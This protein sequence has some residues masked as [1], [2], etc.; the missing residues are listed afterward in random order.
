MRGGNA[1]RSSLRLDRMVD[2]K[3]FGEP[4]TPR[5][6]DVGT[7]ETGR[8]GRCGG[9]NGRVGRGPPV[10]AWCP[11]ASPPGLLQVGEHLPAGPILDAVLP[12]GVARNPSKEPV[13]PG[14]AVEGVGHPVVERRRRG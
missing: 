6:T 3:A 4:R 2:G 10:P 5:S 7:T 1:C 13:R 9:E 8:A 14:V 11:L 12:R